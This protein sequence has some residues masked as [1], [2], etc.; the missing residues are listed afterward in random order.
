MTE[1]PKT[2]CYVADTGTLADRDLYEDLLS[3]VSSERK[4]KASKLSK[5]TDRYNCLA[6]EILIRKAI[7]DLGLSVCG[8]S[9]GYNRFGK[10]YL[11]NVPGFFFSI[12]HSGSHLLLAAGHSPLGCDTEEIGDAR[13]NVAKRFFS[14]TEYEAINDTDDPEERACQFYAVWTMRESYIKAL[15]QGLNK[16]LRSF[17]LIKDNDGSYLVTD[18]ENPCDWHVYSYQEISGV[19]CA[20]ALSGKGG[21]PMIEAVDIGKL[22]LPYHKDTVKADTMKNLLI[23]QSPVKHS[24][25]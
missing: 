12:S 5:E 6:A 25:G 14:S 21:R 4:E 20:V 24:D 9:Y 22:I 18:D 19:A 7:E 1:Y 13:M 17:E 11:K 16:G 23:R 2:V 15:G 8:I 10:P 3:L